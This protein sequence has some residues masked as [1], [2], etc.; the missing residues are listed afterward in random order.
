MFLVIHA[1]Q[2]R[3]SNEVSFQAIKDPPC[4]KNVLENVLECTKISFSNSV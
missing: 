2:H 3:E 1:N 4:M